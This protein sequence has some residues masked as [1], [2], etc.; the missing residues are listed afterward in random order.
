MTGRWRK[1]TGCTEKRLGAAPCRF[2]LARTLNNGS[3]L[4]QSR[5]CVCVCVGGGTLLQPWMGFI[6]K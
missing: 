3:Q 5:V 4:G 6:S 1:M 2:G